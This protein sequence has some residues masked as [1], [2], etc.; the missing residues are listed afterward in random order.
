MSITP[1]T[2]R[3][4]AGS[5]RPPPSSLRRA[6][7]G[8]ARVHELAKELGKTSKDIMAKLTEM[9]EFVKSPVLDH[10]GP[11][12][13]QAAGRLPGDQAGGEDGSADQRVGSTASQ[14]HQ[15][16][17]R[18]PRRTRAPADCRAPVRHRLPAGRAAAPTASTPQSPHR[19]AA[20]PPVAAPAPGCARP[21]P[22][23]PAP[24]PPGRRPTAG[25][26]AAPA[27]PHRLL[28]SPAPPA[29][30][31]GTRQRHRRPPR[32][33]VRPPTARPLQHQRSSRPARADAP[34]TGT[35]PGPPGRWRARR[36]APAA[37][38]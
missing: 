11:R 34:G 14:R 35:P 16:R 26:P 22:A 9:G 28:R 37:D 2:S 23:A 30:L 18:P 8:K 33:G 12:R 3:G 31:P 36:A 32:P 4:R 38:G 24:R 25:R 17:P 6:V 5:H 27:A 15:R 1:G 10:R 21:Q 19:R 13:P 20:A 7:A 29:R